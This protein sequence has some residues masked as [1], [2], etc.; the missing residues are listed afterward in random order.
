MLE[1]FFL[2]KCSSCVCWPRW[3]SVAGDVSASDSPAR[4]ILTC[5]NKCGLGIFT[6]SAAVSQ[7]CSFLVVCALRFIKSL[8]CSLLNWTLS[9]HLFGA[10]GARSLPFPC[11]STALVDNCFLEVEAAVCCNGCSL[12]RAS[13]WI[14][15]MLCEE[16]KPGTKAEHGESIKVL[17]IDFRLPT[18]NS[19]HAPPIK[20][21]STPKWR[22]PWYCWVPFGR[23]GWQKNCE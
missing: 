10:D 8:Y 16:E 6:W 21:I 22:W 2:P 13:R 3:H 7:C 17:F 15:H 20:V 9:P 12:V 11:N 4:A 14:D 18:R 19:S 23:K 5:V 1:L